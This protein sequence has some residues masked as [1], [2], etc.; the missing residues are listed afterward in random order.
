MLQ[1]IKIHCAEDSLNN[2]NDKKNNP[3]KYYYFYNYH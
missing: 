2:I 3:N 1:F